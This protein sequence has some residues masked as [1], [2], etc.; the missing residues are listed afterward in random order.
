MMPASFWDRSFAY[1][2]LLTISVLC[3]FMS[4]FRPAAIETVRGNIEKIFTPVVSAVSLP[5][6]AGTS[7]IRDITGLA[8]MQASMAELK[9]ENQ[10]L[11][12]W[13][14]KARV[15]E[16]DNALLKRLLNMSN[17]SVETVVSARIIADTKNGFANTLLIDR[18]I[19][20]GVQKN[21]AVIGPYGM[22]GRI[23][24][25]NDGAAR[26]L[27]L[28]DI[29]SRVPV[30]ILGTGHHAV[31]AGRN[32]GVLTLI[33]LPQKIALKEGMEV[34]T[35]GRGGVFPPGLMIGKIIQSKD[36]GYVVNLSSDLERT[37]YVS[38]LQNPSNPHLTAL[39]R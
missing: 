19:Q 23:L 7:L 8:D 18:G 35:S 26:V 24:N 30:Q 17:Q 37:Q 25:T 34:V 20:D 10:R 5:M 32:E 36:Q 21:Q 31:L 39:H 12:Q 2:L 9:A 1:A 13:Y 33:H 11:T 38:V 4:A 16:A 15:L 14:Q 3:I 29:N 6:Q 22:I 28:N 27:L